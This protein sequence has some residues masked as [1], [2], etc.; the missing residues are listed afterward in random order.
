[1]ILIVIVF[2]KI[3]DLKEVKQPVQKVTCPMCKQTIE[4]G[5]ELKMKDYVKKSIYFPHIHLHGNPLHSLICYINSELK[6]RNVGVIK[7]I[8]V[9]RDSATFSEIM[10]KWTNPY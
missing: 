4:L 7:S 3:K 8:E 5:I 9:S 10:K 1:M 2:G 6:V